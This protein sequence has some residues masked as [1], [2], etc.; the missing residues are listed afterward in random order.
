M[1]TSSKN[2]VKIRFANHWLVRHYVS[3]D[4][5]ITNIIRRLMF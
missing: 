3:L 1:L 4:A 5:R 2:L